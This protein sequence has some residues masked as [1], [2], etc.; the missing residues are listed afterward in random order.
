M[1]AIYPSTALKNNQREI[2]SIAD[3]EIVYVTENGR[4][5]YVFMSEEVFRKELD[6]AVAQARYEASVAQALRESR[7]DFAEGRFYSSREDL[8][9]AVALKRA[10][11][12]TA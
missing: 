3:S 10:A 11:H 7:R 6:E 5:K 9:N 1:P 12:A 8:M 2:K 4:G